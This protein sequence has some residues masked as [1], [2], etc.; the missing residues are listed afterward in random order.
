MQKSARILRGRAVTLHAIFWVLVS[1]ISAGPQ[2]LPVSSQSGRD[3]CV[4]LLCSSCMD[5]ATCRAGNL[6][7]PGMASI[8][9]ASFRLAKKINFIAQHSSDL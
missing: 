1:K 7:T 6:R 3:G 5:K 9:H 2:S 8:Q 4:V